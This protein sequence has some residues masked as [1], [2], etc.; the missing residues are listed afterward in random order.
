MFLLVSVRKHFLIDFV[1]FFLQSI[2]LISH[3]LLMLSYIFLKVLK[4]NKTRKMIKVKLFSL[5]K[6]KQ[7]TETAFY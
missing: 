5:K 1:N 6:K 7:K 3:K 4:I 2:P